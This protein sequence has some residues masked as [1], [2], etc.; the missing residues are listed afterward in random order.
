VARLLIT[1]IADLRHRELSLE[2]ASHPVV[3]T[4]GFPPCF[5]DALVAVRLVTLEWFGAFFDD[6]CLDGHGRKPASVEGSVLV[7][8]GCVDETASLG[9]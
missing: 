9:E 1:T 7:D 2:S 4:L 8:V 5:L 3:N 6:R